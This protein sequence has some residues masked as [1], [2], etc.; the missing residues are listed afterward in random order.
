MKV[1]VK[2]VNSLF[3][4]KSLSAL[5]SSSDVKKQR[6]IDDIKN[7]HLAQDQ[8]IDTALKEFSFSQSLNF[9]ETKDYNRVEE[10]EIIFEDHVIRQIHKANQSEIQSIVYD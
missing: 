6:E 1:N 5:N 3:Q 8:T 4:S 9:V 7:L 10:H 2:K